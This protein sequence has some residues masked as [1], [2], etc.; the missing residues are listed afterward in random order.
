VIQFA[1]MSVGLQVAPISPNYSLLPGGLSRI[2]EI[3]KVLTPK[4]VFAQKAGLYVQA[5]SIPGFAQ[6]EWIHG[7]EG[8]GY[9]A[10]VGA[11]RRD[12]RPPI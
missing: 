2:E 9:Y 11:L 1:A 4:F 10:A 6:A 12:A 3:A 8:G 7:R 5:R